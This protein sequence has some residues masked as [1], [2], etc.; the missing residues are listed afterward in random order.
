MP[1]LLRRRPCHDARAAQAAVPHLPQQV[2]LGLPVQ[3][4]LVEPEV[5][6][7]VVPKYLLI[8]MLVRE[9]V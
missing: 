7:P 8:E 4:V 3:V 9:R 6:L 5:D 2:P 1:D